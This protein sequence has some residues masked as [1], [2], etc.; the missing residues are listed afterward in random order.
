MSRTSFNDR[1]D[2][3]NDLPDVVNDLPDV[4]RLPPG[5][6]STTSRTSFNHLPDV[7]NDL[8]DIVQLPLGH[9]STTS[10]TSFHRL[11]E[12]VDDVAVTTAAPQCSAARRHA[13]DGRA[14]ETRGGAASAAAR[15]QPPP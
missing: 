7:T 5:H 3:M 15:P 14:G 4:V 11:S 12:I 1:S 9:R 6:P 8:P 10:R 2:V 13:R